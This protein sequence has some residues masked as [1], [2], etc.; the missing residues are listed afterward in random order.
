MS[1]ASTGRPRPTIRGSIRVEPMRARDAEAVLRIYG[2]GIATGIATF[3]TTVPTW[4]DW[5]AGHRPDCRFVARIE[6]QVVGWTALAPTPPARSMPALRE[7][8]YVAT[9]ARGQGIGAAL[10]ARLVPASER[11]GVWTLIAGIQ[12]ENAAAC[13]STRGSVSAD[14]RPTTRRS[15]R[16]GHRRDV[17]LLE[18]RSEAIGRE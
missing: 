6:G 10:L 13:G 3:D 16:R 12:A 5:D 7:S 18:R 9:A 15:G 4:E 8:V 17:V 11:A 1:G 2:E 14:R